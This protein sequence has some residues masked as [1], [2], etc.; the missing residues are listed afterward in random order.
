MSILPVR[1]TTRSEFQ[2]QVWQR[3]MRHVRLVTRLLGTA[4]IALCIRIL[5][6]GATTASI[7]TAT[8]V[9]VLLLTSLLLTRYGQKVEPQTIHQ[10]PQ[11]RRKRGHARTS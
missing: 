11:T 1:D 7:L 4:L 10:V 5:I 6:S 8:I 3:E 2:R 9:G